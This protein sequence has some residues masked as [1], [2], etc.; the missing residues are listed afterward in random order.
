MT[1]MCCVEHVNWSGKIE[2]SQWK[3][4]EFCFVIWEPWWRKSMYLLLRHSLL[5]RESKDG[6]WRL[7]CTLPCLLV[8]RMVLWWVTVLSQVYVPGQ[9]L[10]MS[11][12]K[13]PHYRLHRE[14]ITHCMYTTLYLQSYLLNN[15]SKYFI[16]WT[17]LMK[18]Y[19]DIINNNQPLDSFFT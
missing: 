9:S 6:I 13:T 2:F 3:V 17:Q 15:S 11:V 19:I 8:C 5:L 7:W 4:R 12:M 16:F 10:L 1:S 18:W 14:Q